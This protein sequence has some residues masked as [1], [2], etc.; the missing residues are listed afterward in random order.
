MST[1]DKY[2][3]LK[4]NI[5]K[6]LGTII[7]IFFLLFLINI[8]IIIAFTLNKNSLEYLN[9]EQNRLGFGNVTTWISNTNIDDL[10]KEIEQIA[11]VE[12]V[13]NQELIFAGY[14][15]NNKHSDNEGQ[16]LKYNSD[17]HY[18]IISNTLDSYQKDASLEDN[19]IFISPALKDTY[20]I[21]IGDT[22]YFEITRDN[23]PKEFIVKG[24]FEDPFMGSSMID[25]K[26]FLISN[27]AFKT[28]K[29]EISNTNSINALARNGAML[30]IY[31]KENSK[32]NSNEFNMKLNTNSNLA[33]YE[34]FTYTQ[35]TMLN[36]MLVLSNFFVGFIIAFVTILLI[37]SLV[38]ITHNIT[39]SID[40]DRADYGILKT[41]GFTSF[42]LRLIEVL[43]Y[44]IS[45]IPSIILSIIA[46][47]VI[48]KI[49]PSLLITSSG[50]IVPTS[51]PIYSIFFFFII[52]SILIFIVIMIKT[53][54]ITR[55]RP[56]DL[57]REEGNYASKYYRNKLTINDLNID[58]GIRELLSNKKRYIGLFII[59][60]LLT[61]FTGIVGR[62]NAWLGPN[63]EGL[64]NAFSVAAH[65]IG[66][67]PK[68]HIDMDELEQIIKNYAD[69]E[70]VYA[71]A[72]QSVRIN[73]SDT[74]ANIINDASWF[75]ILK[76]E[77]PQN[78]D[79][80]VITKML[81]S[82]L[83][84]NIGDTVTINKEHNFQEYKVVGIYEC[85][86]E[87][88]SNI[89]MIR[90]GYARIGN[91]NSYIWCYH[92][93]LSNHS[94]NEQIMSSLQEKYPMQLNVHTNSW[95]GLD[96]I[97]Q[98]LHLLVIFMYIITIIFIFVIVKL[99]TSK[100]LH[101]EKNNM[102]IYKSLGF[103]SQDLRYNLSLRFLLISLTGVI[104][105]HILSILFAD[106]LITILVSNFGIGTFTS[107]LTI[108]GTII[109][110]ILIVSSFV[111]FAYIT[112]KKIKK[113]DIID[114]IKEK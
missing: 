59:T 50:F 99:T 22:I 98:T 14:S 111:I 94:H 88:G 26:S 79:E 84:I 43:K 17:Y 67:E 70:S 28:L 23:S 66:V 13:R 86:N 81:A 113:V 90:E 16:L 25:M 57:I 52:V 89:G 41:I 102:G 31:Q 39:N 68:V 10:T 47:I 15:I 76:G 42:D 55:I 101:F 2:L 8:F 35:N 73:G 21:T 80:I 6:N 108:S 30:H 82:D 32:L 107:T 112:S 34:E 103:T 9:N 83:N 114:L 1:L 45:I 105:G 53:R 58:I 74:T 109:P 36:F 56:I 85:A 69:I 77:S 48:L 37:V 51:L 75:H 72:M 40:N 38:I 3:V 5:K 19:E 63:G 104:I 18:K 24:Y 12:L 92:F 20:D 95:T 4:K 91:V 97:V 27:N 54:E 61:L 44:S 78:S 64:M 60:I 110:S 96:S 11:D 62:L 46:S 71:L 93:I 29:E 106:H 49:L 33:N 100:L 87:M 7:A 65:D